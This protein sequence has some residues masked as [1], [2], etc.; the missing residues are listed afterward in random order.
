MDFANHTKIL[1]GI[2]SG[3]TG[4]KQATEKPLLTELPRSGLLG[5]PYPET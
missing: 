1:F 3:E 4:S 5:N 2:S